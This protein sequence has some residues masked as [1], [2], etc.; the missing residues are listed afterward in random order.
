VNEDRNVTVAEPAIFEPARAR[1][2]EPD[3][4]VR[5]SKLC[6]TIDD[7]RVLR[8]IDLEIGAGS[9]L[10]LLGANGAGKSTLLRIIATL[11]PATSGRVELFG[12]ALTKN[13]TALRARI[14]LIAHQSMLYRDLSAKENLEFYAGLYGIKDAKAR[15]KQMLEM[16]GLTSRRN[17]PVKAFSRGMVQ[18]AAIARALLHDPDLILA[19][20]P[21]SGLDAP[22]I[23]SLERFLSELHRSGKTIILVNHD[24]DQSLRL[25]ERAIVLRGGKI[26]VDQATYRLYP[27][28]VL[29]EVSA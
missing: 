28:E 7:R 12:Q 10:A 2:D 21:F 24:I 11:S 5:C 25:A 22:S 19:D 9:Y 20:E 1:S 15:V 8:E 27:R 18:R 13:S 14:G 16:A 29:S 4:V 3:P 17:D 26:V 23:E 6:Q